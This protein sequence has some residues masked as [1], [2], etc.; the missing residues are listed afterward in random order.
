[1]NVT[2]RVKVDLYHYDI[3][4][5]ASTSIRSLV[6]QAR[7]II[8]NDAYQPIF[9]TP[10]RRGFKKT[11]YSVYSD[12]AVSTH[13]ELIVI[14]VSHI[15]REFIPSFGRIIMADDVIKY[16]PSLI[17]NPYNMII[18]KDFIRLPSDIIDPSKFELILLMYIRLKKD[19]NPSLWLDLAPSSYCMAKVI[20][21]LPYV[22]TNIIQRCYGLAVQDNDYI[23]LD[24][25]YKCHPL[26][27][28]EC[29]NNNALSS[30]ILTFASNKGIIMTNETGISDECFMNTFDL[31]TEFIGV[32][33]NIRISLVY[34]W[35][36]RRVMII[37]F[38]DRI[39]DIKLPDL[40]HKPSIR[41]L[42]IIT[43]FKNC[44]NLAEIEYSY[45]TGVLSLENCTIAML[46]YPADGI[47]MFANK[48][49]LTMERGRLKSFPALSARHIPKYDMLLRGLVKN[50]LCS[51]LRRTRVTLSHLD[52][53]KYY[54]MLS[55]IDK[56]DII[57]NLI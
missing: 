50:E 22:D 8:N 10:A 51:A 57:N 14:D 1:M 45:S 41:E 32:D 33:P 13:G 36:Y 5:Q 46:E 34:N 43:D 15:N 47:Y 23:S 17:N 42:S 52:S 21:I 9:M 2:F 18:H 49:N 39:D 44:P 48:H 55:V 30:I 12:K 40:I 35:V 25:L 53:L 38:I 20:E 3:T 29:I 11:Y 31:T 28:V 26:M 37:K 56:H 6:A 54:I 7:N 4:V 24:L 27:F 19:I 16:N